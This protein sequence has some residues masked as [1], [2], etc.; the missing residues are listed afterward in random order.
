MS[1]NP[2]PKFSVVIVAAGQSTRFHDPNFKKPFATLDGKAVWIHS[3]D[4]FQKRPDVHQVIVVIP[5]DERESFTSKFGANGTVL[6]IEVVIGGTQR[7]DSV[8]NGLAAVRDE[9][10]FVAVHDAARPCLADA[11]I[12]RLFRAAVMHRCAILA[13]PVSSTLKKSS[14]GKSIDSTVDRNQLWLAQTPQVFE[15]QLLL[16]AFAKFGDSS[17]TDEAQ[18][19]EMARV[20]VH[21]VQGSPMNIKLTTKQDLALASAILKALPPSHFDAPLHPQPDD[22]LWR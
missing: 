8:R 1:H 12:D 15:R 17:F 2:F 16:D 7:A 18:L 4:R 11:W 5:A 6:G 21:L 9:S 3:A 22:R 14:D 19:M 13:V 20:P 10:D